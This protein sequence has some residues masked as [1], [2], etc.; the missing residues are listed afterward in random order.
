MLEYTTKLK[1]FFFPDDTKIKVECITEVFVD[2]DGNHN[3]YRQ[4]NT[5][6]SLVSY[7]WFLIKHP[8]INGVLTDDHKWM[9]DLQ[10]GAI[11]VGIISQ[12][13]NGTDHITF[14]HTTSGSNITLV[15]GVG[16]VRQATSCTFNSLT[17]TADTEASGGSGRCRLF[18]KASPGSAT[19]NVDVTLASA[20]SASAG[21]IT[22]S[23]TNVSSP[24]DAGAQATY[25]T[26]TTI[27]TNITTNFADSLL[28]DVISGTLNPAP[29]GA[30]TQA[31]N[32]N[33]SNFDEGSYKF[34]TAIGSYSMNWTFSSSSGAHAIIAIRKVATNNTL[35]LAQGAYTYTGQSV[36]LSKGLRLVMVVGSYALTGQSVLFTYIAK[37]KNRVKNAGSWINKD[38]S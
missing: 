12:G 37:W 33:P 16:G 17:L 21:A 3:A 35:A 7:L 22:L 18:Y 4:F 5:F 1:D 29:N 2:D 25:T 6:R 34:A 15:V 31:W 23:G 28:I 24:Y 19:T 30:Q 14:S 26:V 13:V 9:L 38:K 11:A 32:Q 36:I 27:T 20:G 8:V 10:R